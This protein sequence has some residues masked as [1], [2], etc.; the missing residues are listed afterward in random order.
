MTKLRTVLSLVLCLAMVF[1][2]NFACAGENTYH[3]GSYTGIG[4]GRNGEITVSVKVSEN[5]IEAIEI[6]SHQETPGICEA[7]FAKIPAAIIEKQSLAVDA[8]A[9]AT[10]TSEGVLA[11]VINALE[12]AGA[13]IDALKSTDAEM[14]LT[15]ETLDTDVVIVGAGISGIMAAYELHNTHPEISF[16]VLE[17]LDMIGGSL[18]TSGGAIVGTGS[19]LHDAAGVKT[20]TQEIAALFAYTSG[21]EV[22]TALIENVFE[23]SEALLNMMIDW[24]APFS[25]DLAKASADFSPNICALN[26]AGKGAAH[27]AFLASKIA[28]DGLDVRTGTKVTDLIVEN[29]TVCGVLA[30]DAQ[31]RYTVHAKAVLLATGG[32]GNNP[33]LMQEYCPAY[34]NAIVSANAGAEGDGILMTR[35]FGTQV[36]GQ[37]VMGSPKAAGNGTLITS[38]FLVNAEGARF[39]KENANRM[40]IMNTIAYEQNGTAYY[41]A[42]ANYANAEQIQKK[43][44]DGLLVP[45]DTLDAMAEA[46]GMNPE[47]LK[48][49][50]AA[51]NAAADA[52][53]TLEFGL[54]AE[55]ATKIEKAPFYAEKVYLRYFGTIPGIEISDTCQVLDGNG[56]AVPG[57]YAS[58]ELTAGNAFTN[59]YPGAGIGIGYAAN[60]GK[61]AAQ[62]LAEELQKLLAK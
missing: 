47:T 24:G 42:D 4:N 30:E 10:L 22:R 11:A 13:D 12:Q 52:G 19:K 54:P 18:T 23:G 36:V 39:V 27:T 1:S 58:G 5:A 60:S 31:S 43:I 16:V 29:G 6:A 2:L 38:S 9:G 26:A 57:L 33:E 7:A 50:V 40:V 44:A 49:T 17:K 21:E 20:N 46:L 62:S 25:G 14:E 53:N 28:E 37:G 48:A 51:Y 41:L 8:V 61:F 35:Q 55:K 56:N 45:Y 15:E 59:R 32:F 34:S 3:A